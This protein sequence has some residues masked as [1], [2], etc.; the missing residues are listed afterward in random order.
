MGKNKKKQ[1][2]KHA[3]GPA[4]KHNHTEDMM[5]QESKELYQALVQTSPDAV[6]VTDMEGN[7]IQVSRQTLKLHGF[8]HA[9]ELIGKSAFSLIAPE[10]HK[11]AEKNLRKTFEKGILK[12]AVYTLVRKD[13]TCFKGE[14]SAALIKDPSGKP[15]A[16]IATTRDI[17]KR[18]E[19]EKELHEYRQHLEKLVKEH[20]EKL[21]KRNKQLQKEMKE[22]KRS[23]RELIIKNTAMESSLNGIAIADLKG[24]LTYANKACLEMWGYDDKSE[25]LHKSSSNFSIGQE[26]TREL[27][28]AIRTKGKWIGELEGKQKDGKDVYI[29]LSAN[30]VN[31]K[32]GTP[33]C[34]MASFTDI[35]KRKQAEKEKNEMQ[36]QLLQA[37]KME[38]IGTLTGGM[39]HDF[40]NVMTI[41]QS[42]IDIAMTDTKESDPLYWNLKQIHSASAR[43]SNL[44]RQLLLFSSREP[45]IELSS[46]DIKNAVEDLLKMLEYTF[47]ESITI[48][49]HLSSD[50]WGILGDT[51]SIE[52]VVMNLALNAKDAMPQGGT[53]TLRAE[54]T[55]LD[56]NKCNEIPNTR[57]GKYV[58]LTVKDTGTGMS[59][60]IVEHIFEP[61]F[62]TKGSTGSGLGLSTA[63]GIIK[64]H[65]GG[66]TVSSTQGKGTEFKIYLPAFPLKPGSEPIEEMPIINLKG[67]GEHIL[68]IEDERVIREFAA[69]LLNENGYTVFDAET[70]Q[71][72]VDIFE[73]E[74]RNFHLIFSDVML[75]DKDGFK[76]IKDL[77]PHDTSIKVLLSSGL[78][79]DE[80]QISFIKKR[81]YHFIKKPYRVANLLRVVYDTLNS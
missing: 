73:R 65:K 80:S 52:Q 14:L 3:A 10:D 46:V 78:G 43:A 40:N 37:Q 7:I 34:I 79:A 48:E 2:H 31:D 5:L 57:P 61:F 4:K 27:I 9:D 76:F 81:G 59:E 47:D 64:Q 30:L 71:E 24:N 51:G 69:N 6:T 74:N 49:T 8:K 58:C 15:R 54:N 39:A 35:T 45:M 21:E 50:L 70:P 16:F 36:A 20:T 63:Y 53:L 32:K 68:I 77:I 56:E 38:A 72:A 18:L 22:R 17:T 66:I 75:Q 11:K 19:E 29:Q 26:K 67:K 55:V 13:G 60:D 25:F 33:F 23:E 42:Y 28:E 44:T 12:N 62:T 1:P 41:I